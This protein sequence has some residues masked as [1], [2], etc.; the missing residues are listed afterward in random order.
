MKTKGKNSGENTAGL[1]TGLG[2]WLRGERF[3][4]LLVLGAAC[5]LA[6]KLGRKLEQK[7][8]NSQFANFQKAPG[9]KRQTLQQ[10]MQVPPPPQRDNMGFSDVAQDLSGLGGMES[11]DDMGCGNKPCSP[12]EGPGCAIPAV[13]QADVP[14]E[15][16]EFIN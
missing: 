11:I 7:K 10:R 13:A 6:Y 14:S 2:K 12:M 1:G 3:K 9:A 15:E 16:F 5:F 8:Q 4:Y